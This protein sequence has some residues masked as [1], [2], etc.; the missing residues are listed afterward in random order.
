[1]PSIKDVAKKAGVSKSTVSLVINDNGYVSKETKEK[2]EAAIKELNYI[3]SKLAQN[4]SRQHSGIVAIVVPDIMHPFFSTYIKYAEKELF[5]KGYMTMVCSIVGRE[6]NEKKYIDM[7]NRKIVDGIIMAG[8][9]LDIDEY[10]K[11]TRP[12]VSID[13]FLCDEIPV[14]HSNHKQ[15]AQL[16]CDC[17]IRAGC[18]NVVQFVGSGKV[19]MESDLFNCYCEEILT[20]NGVE[21]NSINVGHNTFTIEEYEEAAYRLFEKYS[22]V[23]GIIGVDLSILSC[24]KMANEK[25]ILVPQDLKLI[26]FDGTYVTRSHSE[27]TSV[28]QP[29]EDIA[30]HSVRLI[31]DKI[32]GREINENNVV[33]D[34]VLQKGETVF[35]KIL[36]RNK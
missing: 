1:M 14:V 17:L 32:Q 2:V 19:K 28:V 9:S 3:P 11:S 4:F 8:H 15:A 10:K 25:R 16:A 7:L 21:V 5:S 29:I 30:K 34:V 20:Q 13:R 23:D 35:K 12:I 22:N 26:A 6:E 24:L 27:I 36:T 31:V 33:L 18:K